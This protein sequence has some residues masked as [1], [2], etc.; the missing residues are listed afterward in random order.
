MEKKPNRIVKF[1][2]SRKGIIIILIGPIE[3]LL[4]TL[5]MFP[6]GFE[7]FLSITPWRPIFGNWWETNIIGVTNYAKLLV[8]QT[9]QD[10]RFLMSLGRT[11]LLAVAAVSLEL[12]LG[13]VLATQFLKVFPGKKAI[14]SI[15]LIP[16]M[17]MPVIVGY[18]FYMMFL[19]L[20]PINA[21]IGSAIGQEFIFEWFTSP[22]YAYAALIMTDVWHWTPF[23]FLIMYSGMVALPENPIRAARVLG[24]SS[25]R[26]FWQIKLP[27][28]KLIIM[29]AVVIRSMEVLKFFDEIFI[30]TRGGPGYSTETISMWTYTI[31]ME[32]SKHAYAAAGGIIVLLITITLIT[33]AL[34]RVLPKVK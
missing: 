7:V 5:L 26:I 1:F 21:L 16:M 23:M 28:L 13:M 34:Y 29:L 30:M 17:L 12:I 18:D 32:H 14:F 3:V 8:P 10:L 15:L 4:L 20:G 2:G 11:A 25:W 27:M 19:P 24:A 33:Y 31:V 9:G 6:L 22:T